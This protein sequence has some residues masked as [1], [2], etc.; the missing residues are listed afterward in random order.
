VI[1]ITANYRHDDDSDVHE[2]KFVEEDLY[3]SET[4]S[5]LESII[6]KVK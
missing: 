1:R 6:I 4:N 3:D 5:T 2:C